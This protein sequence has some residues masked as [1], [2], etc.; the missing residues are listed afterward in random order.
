VSTP[1]C[2]LLL[3]SAASVMLVGCS[4]NS[5]SPSTSSPAPAASTLATSSPPTTIRPTS[6]VVQAGDSLATIA[7]RFGLSRAQLIFVNGIADPN[8]I[9]VGQ[10]LIIPPPPTTVVT[11]PPTEP[12]TTL[13]PTT[14]GGG[15]AVTTPG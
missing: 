2:S 13:P 6:Y 3:L 14:L 8:M 5:R 7:S 11:T 12:P 9:K 1:F 10:R 4:N 15:P